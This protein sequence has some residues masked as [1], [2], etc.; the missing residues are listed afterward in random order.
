MVDE[1]ESK[2]GWSSG[3][4]EEP[5]GPRQAPDHVDLVGHTAKFEF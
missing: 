4:G 1:S 5:W 2:G 3:A